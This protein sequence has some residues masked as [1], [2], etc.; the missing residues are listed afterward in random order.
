MKWSLN[1]SFDKLAQQ[2]GLDA[3]AD[4]A[5]SVGISKKDSNGKPMPVDA[6]D[7]TGFGIGIGDYPVSPLDQAVGYSTFASGGTLNP[8]Y[9]VKSVA[10][11]TKKVLYRHK[12]A[13][14]KVLDPA[15]ANDV[16]LSLQPIADWS[17]VALDAGRV[18]A[19]KT[20]TVGIAGTTGNSD[21]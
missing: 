15:V 12:V 18:S 13:A 3:V 21:A 1:T 8:S 10:T 2:A 4:L 17:H 14:K 9:F 11:S 16:T 20:G 19:A 7:Q 5:H 6:D